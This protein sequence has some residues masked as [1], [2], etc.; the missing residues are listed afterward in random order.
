[1][2]CDMKLNRQCKGKFYG[3]ECSR[4]RPLICGERRRIEV[5][6]ERI[7]RG[8]ELRRKRDLELGIGA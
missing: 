5:A 3:E 2:D 1:M 6:R 7:K 8:L 4:L